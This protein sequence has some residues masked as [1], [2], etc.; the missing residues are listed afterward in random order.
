M[1]MLFRVKSD[2]FG[3]RKHEYKSEI[4]LC[5]LELWWCSEY[6]AHNFQAESSCDSSSEGCYS[7]GDSSGQDSHGT[8]VMDLEELGN[9][10]SSLRAAREKKPEEN[11]PREMVTSLLRESLTKQGY[12]IVGT[13]SG[14]KLC[15]WT[16]VL[17]FLCWICRQAQQTEVLL[18]GSL[19]LWHDGSGDSGYK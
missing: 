8:G 15:R 12:R 2:L 17:T 6:A 4:K 10:S 7:D 11:S 5:A 18:L 1:Q 13:H 9:F 19:S 16:K 3:E 14:V